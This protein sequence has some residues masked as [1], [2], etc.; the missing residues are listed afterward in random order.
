MVYLRPFWVAGSRSGRYP[1]SRPTRLSYCRRLMASSTVERN[2]GRH[3]GGAV[4]FG[5]ATHALMGPERQVARTRPDW[6]A[7]GGRRRQRPPALAAHGLCLGGAPGEHRR[8]THR[9]RPYGGGAS[10][11]VEPERRRSWSGRRVWLQHLAGRRHAIRGNLSE[12]AVPGVTGYGWRRFSGGES[13]EAEDKTSPDA[14]DRLPW[15]YSRAT[16]SRELRAQTS[17]ANLQVGEP[18]QE[19]QR[20]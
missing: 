5:P 6:A 1:P 20:H 17:W 8:K 9:E 13:S 3:D 7:H 14:G 19:R 15:W 11:P 18:A 2:S 4:L 16:A 10:R 12:D